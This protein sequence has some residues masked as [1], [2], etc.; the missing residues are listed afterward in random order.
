MGSG[1][2]FGWKVLIIVWVTCSLGELGHPG[3]DVPS[4]GIQ[5]WWD[6]SCWRMEMLSELGRCGLECSRWLLS[7][8]KEV[9]LI[10]VQTW[11][12]SFWPLARK[13][14][15]AEQTYTR[16]LTSKSVFLLYNGSGCLNFASC[17][18]DWTTFCF[19][20]MPHSYM[21]SQGSIIAWIQSTMS[22]KLIGK[23]DSI[24]SFSLLNPHIFSTN[25]LIFVSQ[26]FCW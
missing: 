13:Q 5:I 2:C 12:V 4:G 26:P 19:F 20:L 25:P 17:S 1:T 18:Q 21:V 10:T 8:G 16:P 23:W 14:G 22:C 11:R 9:W 7:H 3:E 6:R 15:Q 24:P